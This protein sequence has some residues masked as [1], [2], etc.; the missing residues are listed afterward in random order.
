MRANISKGYLLRVAAIAF[1]CVGGALWFFYD[2]AIT[3]PAQRERGLAFQKLEEEGRI[4]E[5][6]ELAKQNDWPTTK[7]DKPKTEA[8]IMAQFVLGALITPFAVLYVVILIRHLGRWVEADDEGLTT[9]AGKRVAYDDIVSLAK[10]KWDAK[11]IAYAHY[12]RDGRKG[13]VLLDDWKFDTEP[14]REILRKI[15]S[16]IPE[17]RITGGLPEA[18]KQEKSEE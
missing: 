4:E 2:G 3:Y 12:E 6:P 11:G 7:P 8:E 18:A 17:D 5:W 16:Q 1:L 14:T 15:E 13:R 10:K 9:S